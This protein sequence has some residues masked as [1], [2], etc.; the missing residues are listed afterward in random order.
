MALLQYWIILSNLQAIWAA[1]ICPAS[2]LLQNNN[3]HIEIQV[4]SSHQVGAGD[5]A[6]VKDIVLEAALTTIMDC[7]DSVAA[8]DAEDKA[9]AYGNWH[10]SDQWHFGGIH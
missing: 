2:I 3:L 10:G 6:G 9:L 1:Q 5:L 4:D 8:V 7:E